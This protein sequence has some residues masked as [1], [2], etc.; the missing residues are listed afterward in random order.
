MSFIV[1]HRYLRVQMESQIIWVST[2]A[3]LFASSVNLENDVL[4]YSPIFF[5]LHLNDLCC[6]FAPLLPLGV[7]YSEIH[8]FNSVHGALICIQLL[9]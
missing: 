9:I 5:S 2:Q 1:E 7:G 6:T 3:L 8:L 4:R